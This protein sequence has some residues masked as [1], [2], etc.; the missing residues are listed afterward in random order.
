MTAADTRVTTTLAISGMTCGHCVQ[1]VESAL[2]ELPDVAARVALD[3]A[4]AEVRHPS[5]VP[6][7]ALVAAIEDA[8]YTAELTDG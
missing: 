6:L 4:T 7:D 8:G 1:H 2:A 5:T 3:T